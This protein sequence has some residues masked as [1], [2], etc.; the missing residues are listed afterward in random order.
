ML[1][2]RFLIKRF[3]IKFSIKD[4]KNN[5]MNHMTKYVDMIQVATGGVL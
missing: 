4:I 2:S 1:P 5:F 3:L